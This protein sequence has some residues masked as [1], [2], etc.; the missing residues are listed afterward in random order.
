MHALG[1]Q[2]NKNAIN[3]LQRRLSFS[4]I[5]IYN[6][7]MCL[8]LRGG[9]TLL[10]EALRVQA[11]WASLRKGGQLDSQHQQ[12]QGNTGH[13][14]FLEW[15]SHPW[16]FSL[17]GLPKWRLFFQKSDKD[18]TDVPGPKLTSLGV[19]SHQWQVH[20]KCVVNVSVTVCVCVCERERER[21]LE[22]STWEI[23]TYLK[24]TLFYGHLTSHYL[25]WNLQ[26]KSLSKPVCVLDPTRG[27][28]KLSTTDWVIHTS[29]DI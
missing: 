29:C 3:Q 8:Q 27:P 24:C 26:I 1:F 6:S 12:W 14:Q 28:K 21:W 5:H 18:T 4:A 11:T 20:R 10:R 17:T 16:G 15:S 2:K 19:G 9:S 7:D 23:K 22:K 25:T 13:G